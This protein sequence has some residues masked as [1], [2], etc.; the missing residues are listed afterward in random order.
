MINSLNDVKSMYGKLKT[1]SILNVYTNNVI[2]SKTKKLYELFHSDV[3][4]C[5]KC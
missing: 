1:F 5:R 2:F 3:G 4:M